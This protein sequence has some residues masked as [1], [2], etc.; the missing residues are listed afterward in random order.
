MAAAAAAV[1][2]VAATAVAASGAVL[3]VGV[4]ARA[5]LVASE[6]EGVQM[7]GSMPLHMDSREVSTLHSSCHTSC[8]P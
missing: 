4:E 7:A 2:L 3:E 8:C 6:G 1:A 5:V